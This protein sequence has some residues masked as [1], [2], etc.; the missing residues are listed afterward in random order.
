MQ[1]PAIY[2]RSELN[3]SDE[4]TSRARVENR[5]T[6]PAGR[7]GAC[8]KLCETKIAQAMAGGHTRR[9]E[10]GCG[11]REERKGF[12][13]ATK[14]ATSSGALEQRQ[15]TSSSTTHLQTHL[16]GRLAGRRNRWAQRAP[17]VEPRRHAARRPHPGAAST[18]RQ[19]V[20]AP[21]PG[22]SDQVAHSYVPLMSVP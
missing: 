22:R 17:T 7:T 18:Q 20:R 16:S 21:R 12:M 11:R 8:S 10:R 1:L 19:A 15:A 13:R 5:G 9:R 14:G 6:P 3:F 4:V 2:K